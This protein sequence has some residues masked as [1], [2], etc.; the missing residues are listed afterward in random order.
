MIGGQ[1]HGWSTGDTHKLPE[2][3]VPLPHPIFWF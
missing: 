3:T 2:A 1:V